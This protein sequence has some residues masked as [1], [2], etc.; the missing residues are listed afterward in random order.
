MTEFLGKNYRSG[1]NRPGQRS[2]TSFIN[3]GNPRDAGGAQFFLITK[4]AAPVHPHK[5]LADLRE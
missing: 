1:H 3:P 2:A 4:S 5:S